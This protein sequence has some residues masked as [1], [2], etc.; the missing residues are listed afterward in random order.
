[1]V[2]MRLDKT[3]AMLIMVTLV[4]GASAG[5]AVA[6]TDEIH[7]RSPLRSMPITVRLVSSTRRAVRSI[8]SMPSS[9]AAAMR[10]ISNLVWGLV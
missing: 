3:A 1:M 6:Q 9:I 4:I 2:R 5:V 7:G 10:W 8:S